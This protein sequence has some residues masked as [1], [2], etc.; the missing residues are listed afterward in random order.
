[1][2]DC[3]GQVLYIGKA[4]NLRVRVRQYFAGHDN[5]AMVPYL[6]EQVADVQ[7]ILVRSEK[8]ALLLE[9]QLI[10]EYQP[11]YNVLLKDDKSFIAIR[12]NPKGFWPKAAIV[13]SRTGLKQD[14]TLFGPFS[15]AYAA[16]ETLE[17]I[18]KLFRLRQ[19]S[20][21]E[22]KRRT[23]PCLLYDIKRCT[24][25]CVGRVSKEEYDA[26]VKRA[27]LFLKGQ[28]KEVVEILEREMEKASEQLEFERAG[29]ILRRIK[30][31][32]KTI[33]KQSVIKAQGM[34]CDVIGV[35]RR[36]GMVTFAKL[37]YRGG[38]LLNAKHFHFTDQVGET[39]ELLVTF[40]VQ[41]YLHREELPKELYLP[42]PIK[43]CDS[44]E[45][46]I[47]V[48]VLQPTKG[49]KKDLVL[50]ATKNAQAG[51][52]QVEKEMVQADRVLFALQ[53]QLDLS[54]VPTLI[55]CIDNSNLSQSEPV[56]AVISFRGVEP[57]KKRY[58]TYRI[59]SAKPGDDV[60]A[61]YEVL[62]RRLSRQKEEGTLPDL[63]IVDGGKGQLGAA[64]RATQELDLVSV[65]VIGV[66]KERGRH[67]RGQTLEQIF[68]PGAKEPRF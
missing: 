22:F 27:I 65:D 36:A 8:E 54:R 35:V 39:E 31:I 33:E 10:K 48:K 23:R 68:L 6:T 24:A 60:G 64:L 9:S 41:H 63:L 50:L 56:S 45:E 66:A 4:I 3:K 58:R 5:R 18:Y 16:R 20:D 26:Q 38:R 53:E 14:G 21:E 32:Q 29:E 51:F 47:G 42:F 49:K 59:K 37:L 46:L 15:N 61:M 28:N 43:E 34:D 2:R 62:M 13:R 30:S 57:E 11:K 17:E 1:M 67:D 19:C 25:P 7:T 52:E 40:L 55:D 12:I 44:L